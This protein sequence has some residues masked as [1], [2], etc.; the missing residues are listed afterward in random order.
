MSRPYT[1]SNAPLE[2]SVDKAALQ[3]DFTAKRTSGLREYQGIAAAR[4]PGQSTPTWPAPR[5]AVAAADLDRA[6]ASWTVM[7]GRPPI[8]PVRRP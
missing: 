3:E 2:R 6:L 5:G 1:C 4:N 7:H 8:D